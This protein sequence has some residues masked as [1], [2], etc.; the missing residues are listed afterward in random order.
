[1]AVE[2]KETHRASLA[3]G[4]KRSVSEAAT[5]SDPE[6]LEADPKRRKR[7]VLGDITH[8]CNGTAV[9]LRD[10]KKPVNEMTQKKKK[11][12]DESGDPSRVYDG[13]CDVVE[14]SESVRPDH[15]VCDRDALDINSYIRSKEV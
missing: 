9:D 15:M 12:S 4:K 10:A 14:G 1:M 5:V 8:L 13:N 6:V 2:N 11:N 7:V 3:M